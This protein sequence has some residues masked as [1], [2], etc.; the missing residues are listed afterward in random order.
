MVKN[1]GTPALQSDNAPLLSEVG[2][3][4]FI[5]FVCIGKTQKIR[6]EKKPNLLSF[7]TELKNG[8]DKKI[9]TFSTL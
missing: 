7:H 2:I 3:H 4:V 8:L 6:G 1:I 5:Y 9:G